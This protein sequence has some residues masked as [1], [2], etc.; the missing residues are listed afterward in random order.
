[1]DQADEDHEE[2]EVLGEDS[3]HV[4]VE[5]F[6]IGGPPTHCWGFADSSISPIHIRVR[7]NHPPS[8]SSILI[9]K[10]VIIIIG[11]GVLV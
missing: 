10:I 8:P 3:E 11:D 4:D 5:R 1:L 2:D 9:R 7:P 6:D